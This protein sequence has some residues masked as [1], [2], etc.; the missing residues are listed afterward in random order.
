MVAKKEI[1]NPVYS[2]SEIIDLVEKQNFA[3][4]S[5]GHYTK[6]IYFKNEDDDFSCFIFN[7]TSRSCILLATLNKQKYNIDVNVQKFNEL[8]SKHKIFLI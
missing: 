6:S 2:N 5:Q 1:E 3:S 8:F 7:L 4:I